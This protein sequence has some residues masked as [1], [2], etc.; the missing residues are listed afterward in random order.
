MRLFA[1]LRPGLGVKRWL[2]LL[3]LGVLLLDLSVT[4]V[5]RD[6]YQR[7]AFPTFYPVA[8]LQFMPRWLRA[9][10]FAVAGGSLLVFAGVRLER[11]VLGALLPLDRPSVVKILRTY[12]TRNRGPRVVSIGGGTGMS[13]LLAGL[14]EHSANLTAIVTVADDGGSSGRLRD[15]YRI[16]PPGDIRQCL[17]ALADA[18]P[19][20]KELFNYRFKS[21]YL[22]GHSFGNLFLAAMADVTGSFES[23]VR[24]SGRVL[25]VRGTIIPCTLHDVQLVAK[26]NGHMVV[27]ESRIPLEEEPPTRVFLQPEGVDLNPEAAAAIRNAELIVVGPGSLYTSILPN[28]VVP[29]MVR[30]IREASA[31]KVFI[32]NVASEPGQTDGYAVSDYLRVVRDHVGGDLFDFAAVNSNLNHP[33]P[34]GQWPVYFDRLQAGIGNPEVR[35]IAGDVVNCQ[36]PSRHDPAKLSRLLLRQVWMQ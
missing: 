7:T 25:A 14:K 6:L 11:S 23:A 33:P 10:I 22:A 5:L 28:I 12:R 30:A 19:L 29:G 8:T 24:E 15:D 4:Y 3:M 1:W 36:D 27:G 32:C 16:L 20:M 35:F 17:V 26:V 31:M 34:S 9:V 2:V 18:E 13:T 21:G